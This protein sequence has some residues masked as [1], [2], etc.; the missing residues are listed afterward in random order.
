[1][2]FKGKKQYEQ[3]FEEELTSIIPGAQ[4]V[5]YREVS[6]DLNLSLQLFVTATHCVKF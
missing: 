5:I 4:S 6:D 1:M 2:L 3:R